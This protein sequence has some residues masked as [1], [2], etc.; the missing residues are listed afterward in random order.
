MSAFFIHSLSVCAVHT[1]LQLE[2]VVSK[3]VDE[4]YPSGP[5]KH[6][7]KVKYAKWKQE[8]TWRGELFFSN[9][10]RRWRGAVG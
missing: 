5:T 8:H 3:R 6:W 2:G 9:V 4:P 7:L 1:E 10:V